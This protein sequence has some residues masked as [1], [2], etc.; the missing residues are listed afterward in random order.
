MVV[1]F[2]VVFLHLLPVFVIAL[3]FI[4]RLV[5]NLGEDELR[6]L[7]VIFRLDCEESKVQKLRFRLGDEL[8]MTSS[9]T[10]KIAG[11]FMYVSL[12]IGVKTSSIVFLSGK[13]EKKLRN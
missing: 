6:I 2:N 8:A 5:F 1:Q 3:H 11:L 13:F 9:R 7:S 4:P 12:G 10:N